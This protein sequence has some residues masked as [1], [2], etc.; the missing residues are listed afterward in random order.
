MHLVRCGFAGSGLPLGTSSPRSD[1]PNG[2]VEHHA[3]K[4]GVRVEKSPEGRE[5]MGA[6]DSCS[7]LRRSTRHL[8]SLSG[9][10]GSDRWSRASTVRGE[11]GDRRGRQRGNARG[12]WIGRRAGPRRWTSA[13]SGRR[14]SVVT[15][16]SWAA[17]WKSSLVAGG[18][19]Q[20]DVARPE[21]KSG[22]ERRHP[23]RNG[24]VDV[25]Q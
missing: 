8:A 7:K 6:K 4:K 17:A 24:S 25:R 15:N 14:A 1:L 19:S 22:T 21:S 12:I 16:S 3:M 13:C 18:T 20:S 11:R 23:G 2:E 10:R 5:W 9:V